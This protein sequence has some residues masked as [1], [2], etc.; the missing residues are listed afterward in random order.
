MSR[1]ESKHPVFLFA[2]SNFLADRIIFIIPVATITLTALP[3]EIITVI[4][5]AEHFVQLQLT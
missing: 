5:L 2:I 3:H 1:K 4:F